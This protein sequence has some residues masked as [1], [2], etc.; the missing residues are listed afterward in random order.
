MKKISMAIVVASFVVAGL[1]AKKM[2]EAEKT[3]IK[4]AKASHKTAIGE[5]KAKKGKERRECNQTANKAHKDAVKA[6]K[7][8][9]AAP[10]A[11]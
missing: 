11:K 2:S 3:C 4:D 8:A 1:S 10:A 5:C 7:T 9:A 6:C